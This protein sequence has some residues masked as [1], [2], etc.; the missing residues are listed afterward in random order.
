MYR[1]AL[2]V[3]AALA[4]TGTAQAASI[5]ATSVVATA[6]TENGVTLHDA[7]MAWSL[8]A[9]EVACSWRIVSRQSDAQGA[10]SGSG[11]G[12]RVASQAGDS[13]VFRLFYSKTGVCAGGLSTA[14]ATATA[15]AYTPPA[16]APAP[17][18]APDPIAEPAPLPSDPVEDRL[19]ALEER[20]ARVELASER[21]FNALYELLVGGASPAEAALGARSAYLNTIYGLGD[22]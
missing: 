9:G 7:S 19:T 20:L 21:A 22:A 12:A 14:M 5:T 15:G 1:I 13:V 10:A 4:L 8:D 18:P 16:P 2:I 3:L 17:A 6:E 11:A